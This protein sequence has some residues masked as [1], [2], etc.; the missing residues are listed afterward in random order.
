MIAPCNAGARGAITSQQAADLL[1]QKGEDLARGAA[2]ASQ[3]QAEERQEAEVFFAAVLQTVASSTRWPS[4]KTPAYHRAYAESM[5][6]L[7][8]QDFSAA[9]A[10]GRSTEAALSAA[11]RAL[12]LARGE[13]VQV[14]TP[15]RNTERRIAASIDLPQTAAG[16][17]P[18]ST[19]P[20]STPPVSTTP[21]NGAGRS[22]ASRI[23]TP[24]STSTAFS[25][26]ATRTRRRVHRDLRSRRD[27]ASPV[28]NT[29]RAAFA[30]TAMAATVPPITAT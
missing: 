13:L 16:A 23:P 28:C 19:A 22:A 10:A 27:F 8:R 21:S 11:Y 25:S 12:A 29:A 2:S 20:V 7:A 14:V 15:F 18:A 24:R 4:D 3:L 30:A 1:K 17:Q 5:V 26:A 6:Q 9:S